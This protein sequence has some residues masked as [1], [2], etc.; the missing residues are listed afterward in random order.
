MNPKS[1]QFS[2]RK[3]RKDERS[4]KLDAGTPNEVKSS[5]PADEGSSVTEND[6]V[7]VDLS[8]NRSVQQC[9][10]H[11]AAPI[12]TFCSTSPFSSSAPSFTG[13]ILSESGTVNKDVDVLFLCC[14]DEGLHTCSCTEDH[15][16]HIS[17][18]GEVILENSFGDR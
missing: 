15:E 18:A 11:S 8:P 3:Q 5:R 10:P 12:F 2:G 9:S 17:S 6:V 7:L 16:R 14:C 4:Y 13:H 1:L